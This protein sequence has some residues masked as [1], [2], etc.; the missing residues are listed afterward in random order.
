MCVFMLEAHSTPTLQKDNEGG[1]AL[2][3]WEHHP[4]GAQFAASPLRLLFESSKAA[5]ICA[6]PLYQ[7][8][9]VCIIFFSTLLRLFSF[10][11][12]LYYCDPY[13]WFKGQY[14]KIALSSF[15]S[16][17]LLSVLTQ[18]SRLGMLSSFPLVFPKKKKISRS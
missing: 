3:E 16:R 12:C 17:S 13:L 9:A 1:L 8:S 14:N 4:A 11:N 5:L 18:P 10:E 7:N 15:F 2:H 6:R